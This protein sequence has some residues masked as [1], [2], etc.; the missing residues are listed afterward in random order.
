MVLGYGHA[1][2]TVDLVL[3][4][5]DIRTTAMPELGVSQTQVWRLN[6]GSQ[7]HQRDRFVQAATRTV[8]VIEDVPCH[9]RN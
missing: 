3:A 5:L 6:V 1:R 9:R 2:P 7:A 4:K 8:K